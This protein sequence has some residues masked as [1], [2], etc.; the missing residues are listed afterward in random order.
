MRHVDDETRS[1]LERF[2]F[3]EHLFETLRRRVAA[4]ELSLESNLVRGRIEPP[5]AWRHRR[6]SRSPATPGYDEARAAGLDALGRG[7]VAQVVLAGG[8][9]TRFGG[10]VKA[11]RAC[12]RRDAAS[13]R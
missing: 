9:A 1:L 4:G 10:V 7:E 12:G 5:R 6:G 2:G 3:D 13:S 8:M 11:V